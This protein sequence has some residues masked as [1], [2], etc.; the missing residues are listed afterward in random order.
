MVTKTYDLSGLHCSS[1]SM[2]IEG[3]LEDLGVEAAVNY[4]SQTM[5]V[6]FDEGKV[7]EQEVVETVKKLGYGVVGSR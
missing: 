7:S 1:C 5:K 4:H 2:L 6:T 3:D